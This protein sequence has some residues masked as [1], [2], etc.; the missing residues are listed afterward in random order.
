[1]KAKKPKGKHAAQEVTRWKPPHG[2]FAVVAFLIAAAL[3]T[4]FV[5]M[6]YRDRALPGVYV[7]SVAVNGLSAPE[8]TQIVEAQKE[9]LKVV[10][11]D[12]DTSLTA[13]AAELGM[14]VDVATTVE[15]T[16]AARRSGDV[17]DNVAFWRTQSVPL[18]YTN[19]AGLL[20]AYVTQH[21]PTTYVDPQDAQL[22]F[23][24]VTKQFDVKKA[25]LGK[26]FDIK[27]F[28]TAL[29]DL[30]RNPRML[31][32]PVSSIPVEPLIGNAAAEKTQQDI[33]EQIAVKIEF[34]R[35]GKVAYTVDASEIAKWV[36]FNPDTTAGTLTPD[37][38]SAKIEQFLRDQVGG[39]ITTLPQERKIIKD[40]VTGQE[41][42]VQ[43]GRTG[44]QIKDTDKL[45]QDVIAALKNRESLSRELDVTEAPFKTVTIVGTGKWIEVD[46]SQQRLTLWLDDEM[47]NSWL[48]SSGKAATPT[49]I[50]EGRIYKKYPMQTMTGTINGEYYYVPNIKWV[51]YFN[52]GE[53]IHGTYWHSNFG[54][55][56]SHGCINMT[57]A[58]AKIVYDFAPVGTKVIVHR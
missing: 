2:Y 27:R 50:G 33:N 7:G 15:N 31:V 14:N 10:F 9:Q 35:D 47:V 26:G 28:E 45:T 23:N 37:F 25:V 11:Q 53:A 40:K 43:A 55:P 42:V 8:V 24:E 49:E 58:A 21:F 1:M 29:P 6:L 18:A 22:E 34:K 5:A 46:L 44:Y 13:T 36:H 4:L 52:G 12:G 38:D 57:E 30:A 3:G 56:M 20:K 51:M 16:L 48:I 19:D 17:S 32:L 41:T 39:K 54:H